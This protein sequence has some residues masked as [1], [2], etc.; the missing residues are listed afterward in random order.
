MQYYIWPGVW[1]GYED[2]A[3]EGTWEWADGSSSSYTQ[4][5]PGEPNSYGGN[6]DCTEMLMD[7]TWN[8]LDCSD[9]RGFVCE[10]PSSSSTKTFPS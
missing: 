10:K 8:D 9:H 5:A 3:L 2:L 7:G 1:I 4:W 6:E